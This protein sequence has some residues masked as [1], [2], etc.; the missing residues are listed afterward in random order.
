MCAKGLLVF[1]VMSGA[2]LVDASKA[3][4]DESCAVLEDTI[5]DYDSDRVSALQELSKFVESGKHA[6]S[7]ELTN[8]GDVPEKCQVF[9]QSCGV[10]V[11]AS[12]PDWL[13]SWASIQ[14][15]FVGCCMAAGRLSGTCDNV[16]EELFRSHVT[17][18]T[19]LGDKFCEAI[20]D[21][22]LAHFASLADLKAI[23]QE[24]ATSLITTRII[25]H[26]EQASTLFKHMYK[27]GL[28]VAGAALV[29]S[30][31]HQQAIFAAVSASVATYVAGCTQF[32]VSGGGGG[33]GGGGYYSSYGGGGGYTGSVTTGGGYFT[34]YGSSAGGG[35]TG[36]S[37]H[38][39][40]TG[41]GG[42][43][44]SYR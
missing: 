30:R 18:S 16:A 35:H 7:T 17:E 36:N 33:G 8:V 15:G 27:K 28:A 22:R 5:Q 20:D 13:S 21:L 2:A 25:K 10:Q 29:Q 38:G 26:K 32:S 39:G 43:S 44:G 23:S 24:D 14:E 6:A 34:S 31:G 3:C 4:E 37:G 41:G 1:L 12:W 40:Y 11:G 19:V 42:Y 9:A